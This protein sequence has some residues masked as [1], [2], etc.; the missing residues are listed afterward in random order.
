MLLPMSWRWW[1]TQDGEMPSSPD[2]L[3]EQLAGFFGSWRWRTTLDCEIPSSPDTLCVLLAELAEVI[4]MTNQ[5]FLI[6]SMCYLLDL[7]WSWRWRTTL[8]CELLSS[9]DTHDILLAGFAEVVKVTSHTGRWDAKFA[10]Y[11]PIVTHHICLYGLEHS[12]G[13]HGF[14]PTSTCLIVKVLGDRVKFL[15]PSGYCT[16]I[17]C[18]LNFRITNFF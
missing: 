16:V 10:L 17:N 9:P 4:K 7:Q 15:Q 18:T 8:D 12:L 3:Y 13:I 11:S 14:R 2:T 5:A 6:L 1:A